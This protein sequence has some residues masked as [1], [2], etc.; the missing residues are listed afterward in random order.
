VRELRVDRDL[1]D[2]GLASE[3]WLEAARLVQRIFYADGMVNC[4][5]I[6]SLLL[7]RLL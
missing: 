3:S 2:A 6:G 4:A 1:I 7:I 5:A